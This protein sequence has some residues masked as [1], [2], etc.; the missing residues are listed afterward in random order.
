MFRYSLILAYMFIFFQS[1][2]F[3]FS[4]QKL[5][6]DGNP[7]PVTSWMSLLRKNSSKFSFKQFIDHFYHPVVSMLGGQKEPK[8][9]EEI[10]RILHLSDLAKTG[11]WY[12]YQY[13]TKIKF[14]RC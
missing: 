7:Q 10:Q 2:K 4:L 6:Q 5:D 12:L 9:N 13:Q 11:D 1:E 14:Y 3:S 8:I